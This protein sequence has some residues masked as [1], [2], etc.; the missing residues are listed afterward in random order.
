MGV[1]LKGYEWQGVRFAIPAPWTVTVAANGALASSETGEVL[2]LTRRA[3]DLATALHRWTR[4]LAKRPHRIIS[5]RRTHEPVPGL[6][7]VVAIA[8]ARE[9][10]IVTQLFVGGDG[11][12]TAT[13]SAPAEAA[14]DRDLADVVIRSIQVKQTLDC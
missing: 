3:D 7:R 6:L 1:R 12:V 2:T 14:Y 9:M 8:D 11:T 4:E 10:R 13:H 5:S